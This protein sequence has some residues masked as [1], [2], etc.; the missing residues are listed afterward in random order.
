MD[1]TSFYQSPS[2]RAATATVVCEQGSARKPT[3]KSGLRVTRIDVTVS[4]VKTGL[5]GMIRRPSGAMEPSA[6]YLRYLVLRGYR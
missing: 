5:I 4:K 3:P 1:G 6:L 2:P